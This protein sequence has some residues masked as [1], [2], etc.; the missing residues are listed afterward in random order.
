MRIP[1]ET[2]SDRNLAGRISGYRFTL[3]FNKKWP[4][5]AM[6]GIN[7]LRGTRSFEG[8]L[9][10]QAGGTRIS[11]SYGYG[12]GV[13]FGDVS[14]VATGV[15]MGGGLLLIGLLNIISAGPVVWLASV[16]VLLGLAAAFHW[17]K[18][19]RLEATAERRRV[20]I[21]I[22][23]RDRIVRYLRR[24]LEAEESCR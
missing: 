23:E 1:R 18:D 17:M 15:L 22:E 3:W 2:V 7:V 16:A 19:L 9:I 20:A 13:L 8:Q 5:E 11:G 21:E 10:A 4:E 12:L 24:L 6:R 14:L